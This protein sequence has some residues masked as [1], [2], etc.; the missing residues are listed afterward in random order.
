MVRMICMWQCRTNFTD[1]NGAPCT[2][3][4]WRTGWRNS[5]SSSDGVVRWGIPAWSTWC[6]SVPLRRAGPLLPPLSLV[7]PPSKHGWGPPG[8]TRN[9][10]REGVVRELE[11]KWSTWWC[12]RKRELY[13]KTRGLTPHPKQPTNLCSPCCGQVSIRSSSPTS[14]AEC[15]GWES[16]HSNQQF[17]FTFRPCGTLTQSYCIKVCGCD[18]WSTNNF[19]VEHIMTWLPR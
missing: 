3:I 17:I 14:T 18:I 15:S 4:L 10:Y 2:F 8:G 1:Y 5:R 7:S 16:L 6:T 19:K 9:I 12:E 13:M 11:V